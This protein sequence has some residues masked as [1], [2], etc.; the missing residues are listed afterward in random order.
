MIA[1]LVLLAFSLGACGSAQRG[2][3]DDRPF[4]P[5]TDAERLGQRVFMRECNSC[6]P[7]GGTG[8]GPAINDKPLPAAMIKLQVRSGLGAMPAFSEEKIPD[9]ELDALATYLVALRRHGGED[10]D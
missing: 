8:V 5:S 2:A 9:A 10:D 4:K 6:H 7:G 1:R 3:P